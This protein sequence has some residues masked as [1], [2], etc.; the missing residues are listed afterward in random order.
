[1]VDGPT[2]AGESAPTRGRSRA[3]TRLG[4]A[5]LAGIAVSVGLVVCACASLVG[6]LITLVVVKPNATQVTA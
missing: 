2:P 4:W 6:A 1:M 3:A 5:S